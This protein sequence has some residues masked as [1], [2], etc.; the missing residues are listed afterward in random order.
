MLDDI[1]RLSDTSV[2]LDELCDSA[3]LRSFLKQRT[4]ELDALKKQIGSLPVE[5][6]K[7]AGRALNEARQRIELSV[8]ERLSTVAAA[9]RGVQLQDG[10]GALRHGP[11]RG[12]HRARLPRTASGA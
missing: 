4:E 11:S 6:R 2:E 5:D 9:E 8:D 12:R 1:R 3:S 7:D 10:V